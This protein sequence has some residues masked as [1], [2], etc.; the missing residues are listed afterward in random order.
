MAVVE[1]EKVE[2]EGFAILWINREAAL[3]ALNQEVLTALSNQWQSLEDQEA[4]RV[5]IVSGR[6]SKAFVAGA[7]ISAIHRSTAEGGAEEFSDVAQKLF[8]RIAAS[9][10]VSIAAI[11]GFALGGGLELAMALDMRI[12]SSSARLGQ[13]EINLGIIPG[14]GG[15]QRLPRLVG[16]GRALWMILSG[17]MVSADEAYA[18]GLVEA[19]LAPDELLAVA[20]LRAKQLAQKAPLALR[21]AKRLVHHA[22]DWDLEQGLRNETEAFSR[23]AQTHDANEGTAAFLQKR[24]PRFRGN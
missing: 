17:E 15:T 24:A 12:A 4:I 1:V 11:N 18:M 5:V 16:Q 8:Q 6:G 2:S 13:P 10:L 22:G 3:N 20:R 23:I 14:F 21:E 19:V 9:R 7:D